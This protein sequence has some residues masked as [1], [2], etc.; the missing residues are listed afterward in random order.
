MVA[1]SKIALAATAAVGVLAAPAQ[2]HGPLTKFAHI[3]RVPT[4]W[5]S[6]GQ[7]DR[8][9]LIKAQIGLK[10]NNIKGLQEKLLDIANPESSNYGKW[11]SQA[12]VDAFTA[13]A[14]ADVAAVKSWLAANGI[15]EVSHPTNE[16]VTRIK[17][18]N[19]YKH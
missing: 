2:Q 4:H 5:A 3:T 8:G 12:E 17:P 11:L 13:P 7:A 15:T 10:Q 1:F 14:A 19:R 9:A 18:L 16:Y 6:Q